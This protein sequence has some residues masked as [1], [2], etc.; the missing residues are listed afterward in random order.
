MLTLP[1]PPISHRLGTFASLFSTLRWM[2]PRAGSCPRSGGTPRRMSGEGIRQ[3]RPRG[4]TRGERNFL[5]LHTHAL[6]LP[7]FPPSFATHYPT[8]LW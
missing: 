6:S 1:C 8:H 4:W 2:T 7:A 3:A 5:S